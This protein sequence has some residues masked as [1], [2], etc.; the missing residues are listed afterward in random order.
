MS[1]LLP[2]AI[3]IVV[4]VAT[5]IVIAVRTIFA[6]GDQ[7]TSTD[8]AED[9]LVDKAIAVAVEN[10]DPIDAFKLLLQFQ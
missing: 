1:L 8:V 9:V 6:T 2:P 7:A 3:F 5:T 4:T 10:N